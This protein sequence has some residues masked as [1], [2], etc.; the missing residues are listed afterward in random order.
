MDILTILSKQDI[1]LP[2]QKAVLVDGVLC[3]DHVYGMTGDIGRW[4]M[5]T[6]IRAPT[7]T[8]RRRD[9]C[10]HIDRLVTRL[11][12]AH[13]VVCGDVLQQVVFERYIG[14]L[15]QTIS[16][17]MH[18]YPLIEADENPL[19]PYTILETCLVRLLQL[20]NSNNSRSYFISISHDEQEIHV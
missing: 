19:Q 7:S 13:M 12:V 15:L 17:L 16:T 20:N 1:I 9:V 11:E 2:G 5:N 6:F 10:L 8:T 3:C 14:D 18:S 4:M